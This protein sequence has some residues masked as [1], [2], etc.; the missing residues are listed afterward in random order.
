MN[1]EICWYQSPHLFEIIINLLHPVLMVETCLFLD[2][3]YLLQFLFECPAVFLKVVQSLLFFF[4]VD[5]AGADDPLQLF[6]LH[7][8]ALYLHGDFFVEKVEFSEDL[9][10]VLWVV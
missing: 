7:F 6:L 3:L 8:A 2:S 5:L 1:P 4:F 9:E 10:E